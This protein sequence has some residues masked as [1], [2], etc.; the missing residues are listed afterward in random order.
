MLNR[1]APRPR[2]RGDAGFSMM[3]VVMMVILLGVVVLPLARL[4][5][6]NLRS[7]GKYAITTKAIYDAQSIM[8]QV[9]ADYGNSSRGYNYIRANYNGVTRPTN[10]GL[11]TARVTLSVET[12]LDGITYTAVTVT[13]SG[14]GLPEKVILNTW[15]VK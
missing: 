14:G 13:L 1:G 6:V 7:V 11:F 5:I 2:R 15:V 12:V 8:E 9:L 3:E 10:T 4:S